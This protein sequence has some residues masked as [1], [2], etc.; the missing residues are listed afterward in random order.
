MCSSDLD[1]P[2]DIPESI[3]VVLFRSVRELL[4]NIVKH[5]GTTTAAIDLDHR[6]GVVRLSVHDQ[7]AGFDPKAID[8]RSP[9]L[10]GFGILSIRERVAALGGTFDIQS[11]PGR[12]THVSIMVLLKSSAQ[13]DHNAVDAETAD[14]QLE[15]SPAL[16]E[17][18]RILRRRA[19][20]LDTTALP[21]RAVRVILADDH[22]ILREGLVGMLDLQPGIEV[23]AQASSGQIGRAHV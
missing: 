22:K 21:E 3:R 20:T 7:G 13:H 19:S 9:A 18:N 23:I 2:Q 12:G 5:A 4:L 15:Q 1:Q 17:A 6:D 16:R 8:S 11:A 14:E 10:T